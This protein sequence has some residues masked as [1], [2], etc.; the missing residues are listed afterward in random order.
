MGDECR[1]HLSRPVAPFS[2]RSIGQA[3]EDEDESEKEKLQP[4]PLGQDELSTLVP[5]Q[6]CS[7]QPTYF[8]WPEEEVKMARLISIY[9]MISFSIYIY[10]LAL[11]CSFNYI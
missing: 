6:L 4:G 3:Q 2:G 8:R 10:G 7:Q 1:G 5:S 9:I 11:Q